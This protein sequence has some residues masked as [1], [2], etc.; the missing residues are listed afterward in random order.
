MWI[1]LNLSKSHIFEISRH[2][3]LLTCF[4]FTWNISVITLA[5]VQRRR[6]SL[7]WF[8]FHSNWSDSH[9]PPV[10]KFT[11][12]LASCNRFEMTKSNVCFRMLGFIP[13]LCSGVKSRPEI[14]QTQWSGHSEGDL[15]EFWKVRTPASTWVDESEGG[16]SCFRLNFHT[17]LTQLHFHF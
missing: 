8:I 7:T 13:P 15:A 17:F 6:E 9:P 10:N 11:L 16:S 5:S 4:W 12:Y 1:T 3:T 14:S 2:H